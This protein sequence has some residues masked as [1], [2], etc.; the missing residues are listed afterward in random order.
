M[1]CFN[2][3]RQLKNKDQK[4]HNKQFCVASAT[5][6]LENRE[7]SKPAQNPTKR[8]QMGAAWRIFCAGASR[9]L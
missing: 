9:C 8:A 5:G 4:K 3:Q 1:V 6:C 2:R 7:F